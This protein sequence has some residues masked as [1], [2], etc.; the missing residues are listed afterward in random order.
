VRVKWTEGEGKG[1]ER[2]GSGPPCVS[3]NFPK[4]SLCAETTIIHAITTA[5]LKNRTATAK[6]TSTVVRYCQLQR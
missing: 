5:V 1:E 3:L 2:E 4:S 6:H